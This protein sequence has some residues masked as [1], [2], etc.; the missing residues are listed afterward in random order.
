[1]RCVCDT[2]QAWTKLVYMYF[3]CVCVCVHACGCM[4]FRER[5]EGREEEEEGEDGGESVVREMK[6][7]KSSHI[8]SLGK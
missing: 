2:F 1:M 7:I 5:G 4:C 3:V 8:T 6:G